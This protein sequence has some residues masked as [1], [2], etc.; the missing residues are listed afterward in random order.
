MCLYHH[1]VDDILVNSDRRTNA[2]SLSNSSERANP[3]SS[4]QLSLR[5]DDL[6]ILE[7]FSLLEVK[8]DTAKYTHSNIALST[9]EVQ[10]NPHTD[11]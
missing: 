4:S 10:L 3:A 9:S 11:A 8:L 1:S 5:P 2:A 7:A 6:I